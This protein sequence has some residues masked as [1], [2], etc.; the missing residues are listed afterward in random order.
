MKRYKWLLAR[1]VM[2]LDVNRTAS[3]ASAVAGIA[4]VP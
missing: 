2:P 1:Q 3:Q 4:G